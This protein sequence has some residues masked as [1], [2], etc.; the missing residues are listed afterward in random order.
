MATK[1]KCGTCGNVRTLGRGGICHEC[2][3]AERNVEKEPPQLWYDYTNQAWV[4]DGKYLR[5]AHEGPCDCYGTAHAGETADPALCL[6][7]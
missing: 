3:Q 6:R 7:R 2:W 5:C 4:C 1:K